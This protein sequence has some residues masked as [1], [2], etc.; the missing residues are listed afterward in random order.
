MSTTIE[1]C[2]KIILTFISSIAS[3]KPS[4]DGA[5]LGI[6][7]QLGGK[8]MEVD[9]SVS[10]E[11]FISGR[12][13]SGGS[14]APTTSSSYANSSLVKKFVP[15]K[16]VSLNPNRPLEK[17]TSSNNSKSVDLQPVNLIQQESATPRAITPKV[18]CWSGNWCVGLLFSFCIEHCL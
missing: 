5:A 1:P 9:R 11:E 8:E 2:W 6:F 10:R 17:N 18:T 3:G 4:P 12:V 14:D 15:L 7:V 16:P 13:F